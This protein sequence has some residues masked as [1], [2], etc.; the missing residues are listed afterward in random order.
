[1][2]DWIFSEA[3]GKLKITSKGN[4]KILIFSLRGV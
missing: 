1:M 3:A 4:F 2:H